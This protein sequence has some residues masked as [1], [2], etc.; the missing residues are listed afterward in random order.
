[1]QELGYWHDHKK[2][3]Q[4]TQNTK[5]I[6]TNKELFVSPCTVSEYDST[7]ST[8]STIICPLSG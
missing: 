4:K 1:M 7:S 3:L 2:Q 8:S 5:E 6:K